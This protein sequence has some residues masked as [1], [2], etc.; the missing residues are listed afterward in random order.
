[1]A[2]QRV[3]QNMMTQRSLGSLQNNLTR[4]SALQEQL[5]TG[6]ILNR[7]SDSPSGTTAAMR[8]RASLAD[9]AQFGRN[10]ADAVSWLGTI[11]SSLSSANQQVQRARD[12]ALQGANS[13]AMGPQAREALAAELDQIRLGMIDTANTTYLDRPVFGGITAGSKAYDS[14]GTYVGTVGQV[15]R[16]ISD[17]VELRV[18]VAGQDVFGPDGDNVFDHL[19]ALATALR[20]NDQATIQS[21]ID[22]LQ[23]D[24]ARIV[25]VQADAG[26]RQA[27]ASAAVDAVTDKQL[28]LKNSLSEVE[29]ADLPQTIVDLQMQQVAY[30]AALGAT[31]RV[32]QPSLLDFLR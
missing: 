5:S 32:M 21:S 28:S 17:G 3:T 1:M 20:A 27:R 10:A 6:R 8:L 25:N 23:A 30:Q 4:L 19:S 18:D 13:G 26:V 29:N 12:L 16:T 7:P 2:I 22:V 31:A 9:T 15:K 14:A 11:D 24:G